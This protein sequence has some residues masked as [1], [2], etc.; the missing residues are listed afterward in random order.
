[1]DLKG[2]D[3]T[4]A[5]SVLAQPKRLALLVYLALAQPRGHHRRDRLLGIFW[6]DLDAAHARGAL[7]RAVYY[8]R[9]ALGDEVLPG[10]GADE[11][12]V[13][14]AHIYCDAADFEDALDA[15]HL[16]DA[17][18]GY[19]GDLLEGFFLS[20]APDF[21]RWLEEERMRLRERAAEAAR[22]LADREEQN[23]NP[24]F[25]VHW[26][27][28]AAELA[29]Y[30]E[31]AF[32]RLF[33]LLDRLGDRS[34][35]VLAYEAFT[36]RLNDELDLEP[37]AEIQAS[38]ADFRSREVAAPSPVGRS[39]RLQEPT[40]A[41][42]DGARPDA[43]A[44]T[45]TVPGFRATRR[46]RRLMLAAGATAALAGLALA[47]VRMR[48]SSAQVLDANLVAVAP[49]EVFDS[50]LSLWREGLMD[51]LSKNLDGAGSLRTVA[52]TVLTRRWTGGADAASGSALGR[53]TGARV[54]LLGQVLAEGRDSIRIRI[55]ALDA[56]TGSTLAEPERADL[57][58]R[59]DRA[60][61]SL[62][63]DLLRDLGRMGLTGGIRSASIGTKSL[64]AVKAFLRG[65]QLLRRFSLDSAIRAYEQ[66]VGHDS[67]FAP[68]LRRIGL[69][70]GWRGQQGTVWGLK[71]GR[72][73]HGL[74]A[75]DSLLIL[76][77]SLEAASDDSLD[78]AYWSHRARKLAVLEEASRRYPDDPEVWY[79]LGEARFHLGFAVRTT[80][81]QTTDALDRAIALDAGFA[82]AYVHTVQLALDR[83]DT[84]M[85]RRYITSYATLTSGVP[86][87]AGL[88]LVARLIDPL[89]ARS[90]D[91]QSIIDTVSANALFDG[92]R[93]I[94]RWPDPNEAG[95][96]LARLLATGHRGVGV[97]VDRAVTR[98]LLVM[99]LLYRGHLREAKTMLGPDVSVPFAE[100]AAVGL[101]PPDSAAAAFRR[102]LASPDERTVVVD[103][104]W[105]TRC[106]RSFL[107]AGWWAQRR[108]T[109]ALLHLMR[110]G[111]SVAAVTHGVVQ[112]IDAR[113]DANLA[114]A[115]LALARRDT[116]E[117]LQRFLAFPDSLCASLY[118]SLSPPLAPLQ[119]VR[120]E[121][122]AAAGRDRDAARV[123]DEQ[124]TAPLTL[125]SV[126]AT[127]ERAHIAERLGDP[128]TAV[129][130]YQFVVA[131][132]HNADPELRPYVDDAR[133]ALRRLTAHSN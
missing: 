79:E 116:T 58:G 91:L 67:S 3:G 36:K 114:R 8:I 1:M 128:T 6:P 27:R 13:S 38:V 40:A 86:E 121:L 70:L 28:R 41:P 109:A 16:Q 2:P 34:A 4:A 93:S 112:L 63:T 73:N 42:A 43:L 53:L 23:R 106:Y 47:L 84:A 127:L 97:S 126:R 9:R 107:V 37:S 82:P 11:L 57:A 104:P 66:A 60:A 77:D 102:W 80:A 113:A 32:R 83:N 14:E 22:T 45:A 87:G 122:L 115:A 26:A 12:G 33:G 94:Q 71:A 48:A 98:Y 85:A 61:D 39:L 108:D 25:A 90:P 30:D 117:A 95:V 69:V 21:E 99:Q 89:Y 35:A 55:T 10:N 20:G 131:V 5:R 24:Q 76:A 118:G 15:G 132:W 103:P 119:M 130:K 52:P 56:A 123:F 31:E 101:V 29:P 51:Y 105:V 96:G 59:I 75:R 54:V 124:V 110:R 125:G 44:N 88:Q 72:A 49:F 111:D 129:Q 133:V 17:L 74:A 46:L 78:S 64:P 65:E 19:R 62:T 92:W 68:A 18:E 81:Q 50:R 7:S 100:L 120:F